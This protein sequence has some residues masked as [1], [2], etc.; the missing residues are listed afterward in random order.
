M[1]F[2]ISCQTSSTKSIYDETVSFHSLENKKVKLNY[3]YDPNSDRLIF[4][5]NPHEKLCI[6]DARGVDSII[7]QSKFVV[8]HVSM[9]GGSGEAVEKYVILC[10]SHGKIYKCLDVVSLVK[11]TITGIS[12][13]EMNFAGPIEKNGSFELNAGYGILHFDGEKKIFYDNYYV[14]NGPYYVSSDKDRFKKEVVFQN[15]KCPTVWNYYIFI[16]NKWFILNSN[17][18]TELSSRCD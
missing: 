14:L 7:I 5:L 1:G 8:M 12:D 18:L 15:E 2:L 16:K 10:V 4:E 9:P 11:N 17:E 3:G 13:V 6:Y